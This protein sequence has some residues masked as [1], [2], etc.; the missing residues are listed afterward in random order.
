MS[1]KPFT[2]VLGGGGARGLAHIGVLKA[3]EKIG[4]VPSMIVGTSMGA[5]IGGMYSQLLNADAVEKKVKIFLNGDFFKRIELE[6]FSDSSKNNSQFVWERFAAH[7]KQRYYFSKSVL[8]TG[9]FA[10]IKLLQSLKKLLTETDI[11]NLSLPFAAVSSD[12]VTGQETVFTSGSLITS[13]AAS[14]A[15]PG[16]IAP[17]EIN[18]RL[19]VDGTVTSTIPTHAAHVLSKNIIVAIDVRRS[20]DSFKNH[21]HGYEIVMRANEVTSYRLNDMILRSADIILKPQV[22]HIEWNEFRYIDQCI[23][24]GQQVVELHYNLLQKRLRRYGLRLFSR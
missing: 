16:I 2:L 14:S 13:V 3:M 7:L 20:L 17:L 11:R 18:S 5:I 9:K 15:I 1:I 8:G 4:F 6:Q 19:Y 23:Q 21:H 12:L 10:Q 22:T 24:A